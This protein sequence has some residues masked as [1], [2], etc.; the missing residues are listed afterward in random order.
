MIDL[1][2]YKYRIL[3]YDIYNDIIEQSY[4]NE[5]TTTVFEALGFS[6]YPYNICWYLEIIPNDQEF[7]EY[8]SNDFKLKVIS[9][10]IKTL[11]TCEL[12]NLR[13][14]EDSTA[15]DLRDQIAKVILFVGKR[16]KAEIFCGWNLFSKMP[17]FRDH[18][19]P[20]SKN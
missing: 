13:L 17:P 15:F 3:K 5:S 8:N 19:I 14:K 9:L 12:F 18:P 2:S 20:V 6:K 10:S 11:E 1:N 16:F 4:K 7:V